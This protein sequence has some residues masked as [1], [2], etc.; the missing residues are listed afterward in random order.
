M[1]VFNYET[2]FELNNLERII[3]WITQ[4]INNEQYKEGEI[5]YIFC[6]DEYL[7]ELNIKHLN[8][9]ELTDVL[10][11]DETLGKLISGDIFISV[12]RVKENS[13]EFNVSFTDELNRVMIH[14]ILHFC[15]YNDKTEEEKQLI[16]EKEDYYLSLRG[17]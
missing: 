12:D 8:H 6:D 7:T 11:F 4:S 9:S 16:R 1:I 3:T 5:N 15:G 13:K 10:S 14:G 2:K 17:F